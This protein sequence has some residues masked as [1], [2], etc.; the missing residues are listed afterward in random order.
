MKQIPREFK[1][2]GLYRPLPVALRFTV[3]PFAI[4][5][6]VALYYY[7]NSTGMAAIHTAPPHQHLNELNE[8]IS[9]ATTNNSIDGEEVVV[10]EEGL[11]EAIVNNGV[12]TFDFL[13]LLSLPGIALVQVLCWL[14]GHW[15][16]TF[17]VLFNCI[18]V[19]DPKSASLVKVTPQSHKGPT[20][21]CPLE[22]KIRP[23]TETTYW[24][25]YQKRKYFCNVNADKSVTYT[26]L[27]FPKNKEFGFY[28]AADGVADLAAAHSKWGQNKFDVPHPTFLELLQEQAL[29][30]FFVFQMFCVLL[31]SLDDYWYYSLMTLVLL[32]MFES[33]VVKTRQI[34]MKV[35]RDM[36]DMTRP[37]KP[38]NVYRDNKWQL[39]RSETLVP[40]EIVSLPRLKTASPAPCDVL[41]LHG[42]CVVDEAMLTGES[43]PQLKESI[44]SRGDE[45]KLSIGS[46]RDKLHIVFAGTTILQSTPDTEARLKAPDHGVIGY[47]LRTGFYTSQGKLLRT[48]LYTSER[49]TADSAESICFILLLLCAA[50]SA[51]TYVFIQG[52]KDETR[53]RYKLVVRC[54]LI[55]ASAVPP[56]L[57]TELSLAVNASLQALRQIGVFCTEPFRIPFAGKLDTCCFDKTGTLTEN[58]LVLNG[59]TGLSGQTVIPADSD[60]LPGETL[61]AI[62]GCHALVIHD[63]SVS[64]DPMETA[65]LNAINWSFTIGNTA[66][67]RKTRF[68]YKLHILR[69]FPFV[70]ELKRMSTVVSL[71]HCR[72]TTLFVTAKGAPET[73]REFFATVPADYDDNFNHFSRQGMRVIALGYKYLPSSVSFAEIQSFTR[74]DTETD[75]IF[76]GFLVFHSVLKADSLPTIDAL[77][78]SS[79]NCIMITGD[80]MLT[81]CHVAKSLHI[82]TKPA[83]LFYNEGA[84]GTWK[85]VDEKNIVESQGGKEIDEIVKT[86]DLCITGEGLEFMMQ[87]WKAG[88]VKKAITSTRVWARVSPQNKE[89]I[90]AKL[91]SYGQTTLMCGDGTND[92]G[93]L[94]QAH[95]GVALLGA[96]ARTPGQAAAAAPQKKAPPAKKEPLFKRKNAPRP[97]PQPKTAQ[98]KPQPT[99][100]N[101]LEAMLQ[102]EEDSNIIKLGDASVAS[103]FTSKS[104]STRN[105]AGIVK[106]GRCAL[107]T[108]QQIYTILALNCLI[109]AYSLSVINLE[110]VRMAD[111]QATIAGILLAMCFLFV[112][113]SKPAE[114]L[115][116]QRPPHGV[117]SAPI[118][119][120]IAGQ[121][122]IHLV[123]LVFVFES[124]KQTSP[125]PTPHVETF[126][127]T[128]V[129]SAI[130][131][132][133]VAMQ[134][135]TF[136]VNYKGTP[137]MQSIFDNKRLLFTLGAT[138]GW[139]M[140]LAAQLIPEM[141]EYFELV[142]FPPLFALMLMGVLAANFVGTLLWDRLIRRLFGQTA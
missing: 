119:L 100:A 37:K 35:L 104:N 123:S 51:A 40:G 90:V 142:P 28:K 82:T 121:F 45:E 89:L 99:I 94:K 109:Q 77:R 122:A 39:V 85:S 69:R 21:L 137:F 8:T 114:E 36:N 24:F 2:V 44:D 108:M 140:V 17:F 101:S 18:K 26:K 88:E 4:A 131:L 29:A 1:G 92:V 72:E 106:H 98:R 117:F 130:F 67:S 6:A 110:G 79:H 138:G 62:A 87:R 97:V 59:V 47:V 58:N 54:A 111:S 15:S 113:Q 136:A 43:T 116:K 68:G 31:W 27:D 50:V 23:E 80:N 124:A 120:S 127:P 3:W 107:V 84:Q 86:H 64:G 129:N 95:V 32:V 103:P 22:R 16:S 63:G 75:L 126:R 25:V 118:M 48:I 102:Q 73:M 78:R 5:Y 14:G 53:G 141:N 91:K 11:L 125:V 20:A 70:A 30:P 93:A 12:D 57:P 61:F 10:E 65:A 105:I 112:S 134:V 133:S 55:V 128:L 9:G 34:N 74:S 60:D 49:A 115:S 52:L 46:D 139:T 13:V 135:T 66:S 38:V 96:T 33:T 19:S 83:L 132:I 42:S 81:G 76:G 41:L 71:D 56:E 7:I